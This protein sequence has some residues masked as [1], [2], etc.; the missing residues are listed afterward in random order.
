MAN[1][2]LPWIDWVILAV[3]VVSTLISLMR[4]FVKEALSL[5]TL[6]AAV[7]IA[8]LFGSQVSSLLVEY[9]SVPSVRLM[10]AYGALFIATMSVG[11]MINHL[12]S[13]LIEMTGL[14]GTDRL[15]GMIFGLARGGLIITVAVAVLSRMPVT[16]DDWWKSSKLVPHFV[17]AA[18]TVQGWVFERAGEAFDSST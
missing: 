5:A 6:V 15:L 14:S 11:G 18:E 16:E 1:D 3:I 12:I 4:G 8:R 17:A 2:L 9:I 7:V 13:H 10:V